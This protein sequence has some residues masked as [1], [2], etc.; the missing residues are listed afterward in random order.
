[1]QPTRNLERLSRENPEILTAEELAFIQQLALTGLEKVLDRDET[2]QK[3]QEQRAPGAMPSQR[4]QDPE[5]HRPPQQPSERPAASFGGFE[6]WDNETKRDE[7]WTWLLTFDPTMLLIKR[8]ETEAPTDEEGRQLWLKCVKET[9]LLMK[10][11]LRVGDNGRYVRDEWYDRIFMTL[12]V[13]PILILRLNKRDS[14]TLRSKKVCRRARQ[15][16]TGNWK[17]LM[18]DAVRESIASNDYLANLIER[19][20]GRQNDSARTRQRLALEHARKLHLSKAMGIL[21]SAGLAKDSPDRV[22]EMLEE[23]HPTEPIPAAASAQGPAGMTLNADRFH[24]ITRY[25]VDVQIRRSKSGT[26]TDQFGWGGKEFWWPLRKDAELMSLLAE[27]VFRPLAAGYLPEAY[28][29]H[30]AGGRL[31]A[32]SKHPKPGVRPI[33][34]GDTWRRLVAK[35]LHEGT[36]M[37]LDDFFQTKHGRALQFGGSKHGASRMFHTIAAIAE[38]NKCLGVD[39]SQRQVDSDPIAIVGLDVSNAFNSLRREV[40]FEFLSKG[41]KA[42]LQ[43]QQLDEASQSEG[44]DILWNIVQA[45]YGVHGILKYYSGGQVITIPSESGVHQGDPLGSTLFAFT[46]HPIIMKVAESHSDVLILAYADN[47]F[48]IGKISDLRGAISDYKLYLAEAGLRLNPT[49]SEAYVPAWQSVGEDEIQPCPHITHQ[50]GKQAIHVSDEIEIPL[51]KE[52]IKVL[53]CPVGSEA[54]SEQLLSKAVTK[55]KNNLA[56]LREFPELHLRSKLAQYCVNTKI[57]YFLRAKYP[58]VGSDTLDDL[59]LAFEDFY[60]HTLEFPES[61]RD[62]NACNECEVYKLALQQIRFDIRDGGLGLTS[63]NCIA[64][65]ALYATMLDFVI[66]CDQ[67]EELKVRTSSNYAAANIACAL[68][69]ME[70]FG[71]IQ[72][73][74]DFVDPPPANLPLQV[75][76]AE[77]VLHWPVDKL[78][79]Q[80]TV[81]RALKAEYREKW[82][83]SPDLTEGDKL[84]LKAVSRQGVPARAKDSDFAP[85]GP[86]DDNSSLYQTPMSLHALMCPYELSNEAFLVTSAIAFGY[87]MPKSVPT[88][89]PQDKWGDAALSASSSARIKTHNR[90][91]NEVASIARESGIQME[92]G[93]K[94]VPI[95]PISVSAAAGRRQVRPGPRMGRGDI[96]TKHGGIIPDNPKYRLDRW[97][98]LVMDAILCHVYTARDHCFKKNILKYWQQTK[99]RKYR[100][101]YHRAGFAF[102]PLVS[103]SFGQM[104]GDMLR[105]LFKCADKAAWAS[106]GLG[107]T[108]PNDRES[109]VSQHAL[110]EMMAAYISLRGRLF[111]R[112]RSRMLLTI[113]EAVT[114]RL[115]GRPFARSVDAEYRAFANHNREPWVP[116]VPPAQPP[117]DVPEDRLQPLSQDP[118]STPRSEV[119][120]ASCMSAEFDSDEE[121]LAWDPMDLEGLLS[122]SS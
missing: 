101:A 39:A 97:T 70:D 2:R 17:K 9:I 12:K 60:A 95:V 71:G 118:P 61:F 19:D 51:N 18:D 111:Q 35:G 72:S 36:K 15:F 94:F 45:H 42:H 121:L 27:V 52:G 65:A 32:P 100:S 115:Y 107:E 4:P 46:L 48:M 22:K 80:R 89:S 63:A 68:E 105:F 23:L 114:E 24:F 28:R 106:V 40:L 108:E 90:I 109:P 96:V 7:A 21:T 54:Y 26:A 66:W 29:E 58:D 47:V 1:M 57:T 44:W 93:E 62:P 117:A 102:A 13:L 92:A 16:L 99:N 33:C 37:Q 11:F 82:L 3:L 34:M 81:A 79:S 20:G 74:D 67:H 110:D 88:A 56:V 75:P 41:C 55:I 8:H 113:A 49:E 85:P 64:P 83:S 84:R 6:F 5:A 10:Q 38:K 120:N 104:E 31:V 119:S 122:S 116:A 78:P 76:T 59:D 87:P 77:A 86:D 91:A 112:Y 73:A 69:V 30:L 14:F 50:D 43:G 25:W 98:R 53:G 103:N